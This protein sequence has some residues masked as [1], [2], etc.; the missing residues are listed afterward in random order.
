MRT[1]EECQ[2]MLKECI[3]KREFWRDKVWEWEKKQ[4]EY[5]HQL[6]DYEGQRNSWSQRVKTLEY[7]LGIKDYI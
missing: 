4:L 5:P 1:K 6:D 7:V 2:E 3:E